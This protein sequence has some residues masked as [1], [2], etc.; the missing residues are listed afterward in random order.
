[1]IYG[2]LSQ[3]CVFVKC[4]QELPPHHAHDFE[5]FSQFVFQTGK[6]G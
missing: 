1:M 2:K 5:G 4:L 6:K 3:Q